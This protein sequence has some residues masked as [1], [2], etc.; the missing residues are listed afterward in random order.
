MTKLSYLLPALILISCSL[1]DREADTLPEAAREPSAPPQGQAGAA[2]TAEEPL[3]EAPSDPDPPFPVRV[4][5][6]T[7]PPPI[8]LPRTPDEPA[9]AVPQ[10]LH[11]QTRGLAEFLTSMCGVRLPTSSSALNLDSE[12]R[13]GQHTVQLMSQPT[14]GTNEFAL[15]LVVS[16]STKA[17]FVNDY[18]VA[19]I[20]C[21]TADDTPCPPSFDD[22]KGQRRYNVEENGETPSM[23]DSYIVV[24]LLKQ[25][26]YFQR[27]RSALLK[28]LSGTAAA[29]AMDCDAYTLAVDGAVPYHIL[30]SVIHTAGFADLTRARLV[31]L[32]ENNSL[33][34]VPLLSPRLN[35]IQ[36][37]SYH[38][39]GDNWWNS[40]NAEDGFATAYLAYSASLIAD[41][42]SGFDKPRLPYCFPAEIA[43]DRI[44]ED[45]GYARVA[46]DQLDDYIVSIRESYSDLF[47]QDLLH[48]D[49]PPE[50]LGEEESPADE[51]D[52]MAEDV[53]SAAADEAVEPPILQPQLAATPM[54]SR[55]PPEIE[56]AGLAAAGTLNAA[57]FVSLKNLVV[58]LRG[59]DGRVL[60]AVEL[61]HG[62]LVKL[63]FHLA[64]AGSRTIHVGAT[65]D[66]PLRTLVQAIDAVRYRCAVYAMS[67]KCKR[68]DP[69]FPTVY[70]FIT[71]TGQFRPAGVPTKAV[72]PPDRTPEPPPPVAEEPEPAPAEEKEPFEAPLPTLP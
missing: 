43:W 38:V 18:K 34:Y 61:A 27:G 60:E 14:P 49:G 23:D 20:A 32:D 55:L 4:V 42:F 31:V 28:N 54:P 41:D 3:F 63:Y 72:E 71:R 40:Q 19:D 8:E 11:S 22:D 7:A 59:V 10:D 13:L 65:W 12:I 56:G 16:V 2:T 57:L 1:K 46:S 9:E 66:L 58:V 69:V 39:V 48:A 51:G 15:D 35:R 25:L 64:K 29:W 24:P 33:A 36:T 6:Q 50:L 67:G 47:D 44:L 45:P 53:V 5:E 21:V 26:S 30:A 62:D 17:I 70:L 37:L 52:G 68:L